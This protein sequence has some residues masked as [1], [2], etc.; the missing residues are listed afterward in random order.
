MLSD[1]GIRKRRH[2]DYDQA[3]VQRLLPLAVEA[4]AAAR[5]AAPTPDEPREAARAAGASGPGH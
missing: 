5:N 4:A 3:D 2:A 1:H